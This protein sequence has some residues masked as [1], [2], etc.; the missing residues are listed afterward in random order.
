[1]P[2]LVHQKH[3]AF[4]LCDEIFHLLFSIVPVGCSTQLHAPS[5]I[6]AEN[7]GT[8]QSSVFHN[9]CTLP[10]QLTSCWNHLLGVLCRTF[11]KICHCLLATPHG[12]SGSITGTSSEP[13]VAFLFFLLHRPSSSMLSSAESLSTPHN[14]EW[15]ATFQNEAIWRTSLPWLGSHDCQGETH[16]AICH[17]PKLP[18]QV[19]F[20]AGFKLGKKVQK[21]AAAAVLTWTRG[22]LNWRLVRLRKRG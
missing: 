8:V 7:F 6:G 16:R 9:I 21:P 4:I 1:M 2:A 14:S 11:M 18:A 15:F 3:I 22:G 12:R 20:V 5:R 13:L 19:V 10:K 17:L